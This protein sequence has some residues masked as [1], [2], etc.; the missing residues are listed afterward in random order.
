MKS[1]KF[2]SV[3]YIS[4]KRIKKIVL[5]HSCRG[6]YQSVS[7]TQRLSDVLE[8]IKVYALA[9]STIDGFSAKVLP[10]A[11]SA[12]NAEFQMTIY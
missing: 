12:F 9:L 6:K 7:K 5:S 1:L 8:S 4:V 10:A 3:Y 11:V 2:Y